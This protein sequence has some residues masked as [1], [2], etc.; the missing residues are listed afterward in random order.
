MKI[1]RHKSNPLDVIGVD[2]H[3]IVWP[4]RRIQ[5]SVAHTTPPDAGVVAAGYT[6][7]NDYAD[8]CRFRLIMYAATN[9]ASPE[10]KMMDELN[11]GTDLDDGSPMQIAARV[12]NH[13][14]QVRAKFGEKVWP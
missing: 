1:Y 2:Q 13:I 14:D 7:D 3:G 11:Q 9:P 6:L 4:D 8:A 5:A 12:A 10:A